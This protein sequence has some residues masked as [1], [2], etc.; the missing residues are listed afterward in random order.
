MAAAPDINAYKEL[1]AQIEQV[2]LKGDRR[3][4][5]TVPRLGGGDN[6]APVPAPGQPLVGLGGSTAKGGAGRACAN[7]GR[8]PVVVQGVLPQQGWT[9]RA[10]PELAA[11]A[12]ALGALLGH[13]ASGGAEPAGKQF[14]RALWVA[15]S[16]ANVAFDGP[17]QRAP[18]GM[19]A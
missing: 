17:V 1:D 16:S 14:V 10:A 15:N 4:T 11:T 8:Q 2:S 12:A 3:G 5:D 7:C 6:W 18:E 9:R 13:A 19:S